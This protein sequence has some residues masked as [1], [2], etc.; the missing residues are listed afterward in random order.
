MANIKL[1]DHNWHASGIYDTN[2]NKSQATINSD[3]ATKMGSAQLETTSQNLSGG[4][5]ELKGRAD[6]AEAKVDNLVTVS[7][8]QPSSQYNKVWLPIT[9]GEGT[10]VPTWTEH[11]ALAAQVDA[12]ETDLNNEVLTATA[13]TAFTIPSSGSSI[14]KN[15]NGL[16]ADHELLRWNFSSSAENSPPVDLTWTTYSGYFTITNNGGTTS[17]TIR[18]T[19]VKPTAKALTNHS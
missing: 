13:V 18:P 7:N 3:V 10:S 9:V 2:Q 5:N 11:Q 14:S 19:F 1:T 17:E 15:L 12:T 6:T 4:V 16:T 8:T